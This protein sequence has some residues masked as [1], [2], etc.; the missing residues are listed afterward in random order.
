MD[1]I[2]AL[3]AVPPAQKFNLDADFFQRD[4]CLLDLNLRAAVR[5]GEG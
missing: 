5:E 3:V 2:A 4:F 1:Q